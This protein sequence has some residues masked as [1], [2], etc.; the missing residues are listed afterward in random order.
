[1]PT[2]FWHEKPSPPSSQVH[3]SHEGGNLSYSWNYRR[4]FAPLSTT[5]LGETR[6]EI[7]ASG[8]TSRL[9]TD[10][11][12]I[13]KRALFE[14]I[15][16]RVITPVLLATMLNRSKLNERYVRNVPRLGVNSIWVE[17]LCQTLVTDT[18]FISFLKEKEIDFSFKCG[19]K[20]GRHPVWHADRRPTNQLSR[21]TV[22]SR[23][24]LLLLLL[25]RFPPP[26]HHH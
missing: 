6:L 5:G 24:K 18:D 21:H 7:R 20:G 19:I 11:D 22:T 2:A 25:P 15:S 13:S 4:N 8:L 12:R 3:L 10:P 26:S 23:F 9:H 17:N 1:M 16:E 14:S